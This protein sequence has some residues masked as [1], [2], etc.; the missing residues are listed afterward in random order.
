MAPDAPRERVDL[1]DALRGVAIT[2]MI[3]YHFCFDLTFYRWADWAMLDDGRWIAWRSTI[4]TSFL[5]VVGLS[6]A[7]RDDR[8]RRRGASWFDRAFLRRWGQI[9]GAALLVTAGSGLLFPDR[10]VYFGVLH[11][12]AVATWLCRRAPR[13]GGRAIAL[14][15]AAIALGIAITHPDFDPRWANWIG[16]A[17]NKPITEDYVPLFPWIGVVLA[18]CGVGALWGRRGFQLTPSLA[19]AWGAVPRRVR[20]TLATMGRWSLTIY[21]LHQPLL[22]GAMAAVRQIA[23]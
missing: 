18:G 11:F 16:F 19:T 14:G 6:L 2:M 1:V 5:F 12:V 8:E 23:P 3:A 21:L 22:M 20:I 10:F 15:A 7:L 17:T 4:V 13:L 9:V